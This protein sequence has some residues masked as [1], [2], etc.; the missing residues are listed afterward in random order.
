[1]LARMAWTL[2]RIIRDSEPALLDFASLTAQGKPPRS[3]DPEVIRLS[4]GISCWATET[5]AR[6]K[7][8]RYRHLGSFIATLQIP[9]DALVRIERTLGAGHHTVWGDPA[10]I[11][12]FVVTVKPA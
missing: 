1:M 6:N 7:A 9:D 12:R 11:M 8:R 4:A 2:Y 3:T 5:Q 10:E